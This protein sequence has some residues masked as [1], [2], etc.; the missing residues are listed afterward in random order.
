MSKELLISGRLHLRGD[1]RCLQKMQ[2]LSY[3][4]HKNSPW[5]QSGTF[6]Q[7]P[8][9]FTCSSLALKVTLVKAAFNLLL[10]SWPAGGSSSLKASLGKTCPGLMF[11]F[12][13]WMDSDISIK[14]FL[15]VSTQW[16][17]LCAGWPLPLSCDGACSVGFSVRSARTS[18]QNCHFYIF[19]NL[20][21]LYP[22]DTLEIFF[23]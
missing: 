8:T 7:W 11:T 21:S 13:L 16:L 12:G 2:F 15:F 5:Q 14:S 22:V 19:F 1:R 20:F 3:Y 18:E 10:N 4:S 6:T 23:I 17:W 9:D